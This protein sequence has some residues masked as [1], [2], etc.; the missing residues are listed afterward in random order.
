MRILAV[1]FRL[2]A[3]AALVLTPAFVLAE[4]KSQRAAGAA[5]PAPCA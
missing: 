1:L 4:L 5:A 2:L 3:A